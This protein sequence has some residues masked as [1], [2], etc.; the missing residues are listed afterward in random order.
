MTKSLLREFLIDYPLF[1]KANFA[2]PAEVGAWP[3]LSL[4][5]PCEKCRQVQTFAPKDH[6]GFTPT[7]YIP[8]RGQILSSEFICAACSRSSFRFFIKVDYDL[9]YIVKV[10]QDPGWEPKGED[11]LIRALG[12]YAHYYRKALVCEAQD[13]G[14]GALAYC[15]KALPHLLDPLLNDMRDWLSGPE[16][17]QETSRL[18]A[19]MANADIYVKLR[20]ARQLLPR[21]LQPNSL[22]PFELIESLYAANDRPGEAESLVNAKLFRQALAFLTHQISSF[23]NRN[24]AFVESMR[25]LLQDRG[26]STENPTDLGNG[27]AFQELA[28]AV[29]VKDDETAHFTNFERIRHKTRSQDQP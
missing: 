14:V 9:Q 16:K 22:N 28:G 6:F 10:G 21:V 4:Q 15:R 25:T 3:H 24:D 29:S 8:V 26:E 17:E 27:S 19:A 1:K 20:T 7:S 2:V 11:L 5:L 13:L 12:P 18:S 23:K